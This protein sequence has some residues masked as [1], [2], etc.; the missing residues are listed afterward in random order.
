MKDTYEHDLTNGRI[1]PII[2]RIA[3]PASIG[4]L[5]NTFYNLVDTFW[6]GKIST[7]SLAALSVNFPI[8][9]TSL[10]IGV[11]FSSG[12]SSLIANALGR[13]DRK[14]ARV[15]LLQSLSYALLLHIVLIVPVMLFLP[16]LFTLLGTD[17]SVL[18]RALRYARVIIP[19]SLAMTAVQILNAGLTARGETKAYRNIL[20]IGFF[21]N[22]GLDP[23]LMRGLSIGSIQLIGAM[24]EGGIALATILI[25]LISVLY[26]GSVCRK[27]R[28]FEGGRFQDLIP[29]GVH[30]REL[31]PM[32]IPG[33]MNF[34]IMSL[35][36]YV[37]TIYTARFGTEALAAY[38][39]ALRVEQIALIPTMGLTA[40]LTA[41]VGQNNGAR[42]FDR[43]REASGLTLRYGLYLLVFL[44]GPVLIAG[45]LIISLTAEDPQVIA[46][47]YRYLLIQG[48]TYYSYIIIF[49][50]NSL[51][52]GLKHPSMIM[53]VGAYRQGA[54]P[55]LLFPL[56]SVSLHMGVYGIWWSL[57][58]V[59]WS[60]A[61]FS[62]FY[63]RRT[64]KRRE[65]EDLTHI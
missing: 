63:A 33:M 14:E 6:A 40:A 42:R 29:R 41:I 19:G 15:L 45:R 34:L 27:L 31:A 7:E 50:S 23:L 21:L 36:T 35:G 52:M 37:I 2:K 32:V 5:F 61:L 10:V 65:Q 18:P 24:E 28:L 55:L 57:V 62:L 54:A 43:I 17:A 56:L 20:I 26:I 53:W 51:L 30:G 49:Q 4:T 12:S 22:L 60:A 25:Q 8:F 1:P 46:L 44:L 3:I 48:I 11:G 58:I 9:L 59:N 47:G 39:V 13:G 16:Q 38:G 64:L